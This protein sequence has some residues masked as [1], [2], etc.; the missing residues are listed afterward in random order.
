MVCCR[1]EHLP[2]YCGE[3][4]RSVF[5]TLGSYTASAVYTFGVLLERQE[6]VCSC[7]EVYI[8]QSSCGLPSCAYKDSQV[9]DEPAKGSYEYYWC[10]RE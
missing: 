10:D 9:E 1:I 8:T 7:H 2:N 6:R 4:G 3:L 5:G